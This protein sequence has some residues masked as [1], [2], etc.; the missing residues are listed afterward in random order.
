[1]L[2]TLFLPLRIRDLQ[3]Q[4]PQFLRQRIGSGFHVR[5][6]LGCCLQE[7]R[8]FGLLQ[9]GIR[10]CGDTVLGCQLFWCRVSANIKHRAG[11]NGETEQHGQINGRTTALG[12]RLVQAIQQAIR[13]CPCSS[14]HRAAKGP[15]MPLQ[16]AGHIEAPAIVVVAGLDLHTCASHPGVGEMTIHILDRQVAGLCWSIA[17]FGRLGR[18]IG[19]HRGVVRCDEHVILIKPQ[20]DMGR[21]TLRPVCYLMD[22]KPVR[23]AQPIGGSFRMRI[24]HDRENRA[25]RH[26]LAHT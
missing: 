4:L 6:P 2:G 10:S 8:A 22:G 16:I 11:T 23:C 15:K 20:H 9:R 12:G 18:L 3:L 19:G 13:T 14:E 5:K 21:A 1:M 25:I 26:E 24:T 7:A 17:G